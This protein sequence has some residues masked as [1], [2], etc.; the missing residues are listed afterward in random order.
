MHGRWKYQGLTQLGLLFFDR[1]CFP[2]GGAYIKPVPAGPVEPIV[3]YKDGEVVTKEN[4]GLLVL[5]CLVG[6]AMI[7]ALNVVLCCICIKKQKIQIQA[8]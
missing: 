5:V 7:V 1:K 8:L 2:A 6:V 3:I 4:T